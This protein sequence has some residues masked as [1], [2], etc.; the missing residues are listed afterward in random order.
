MSTSEER[1]KQCNRSSFFSAL[2]HSLVVPLLLQGSSLPNFLFEQYFV[3][4]VGLAVSSIDFYYS[5]NCFSK[6]ASP[7]E[8]LDDSDTYFSLTLLQS[9]FISFFMHLS[10]PFQLKL[11]VLGQRF[12]SLFFEFLLRNQCFYC[13]SESPSPYKTND[14]LFSNLL[15]LSLLQLL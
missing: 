6:S 4:Y 12:T 7:Y 1:L 2:N 9:Y 5:L 10:C 11:L 13:P 14:N 15:S 3:S 8:S